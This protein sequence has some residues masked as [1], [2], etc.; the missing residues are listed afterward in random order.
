MAEPSTTAE[1]LTALELIILELD[2]MSRALDKPAATR[3][4]HEDRAVMKRGIIGIRD[5][6]ERLLTWLSEARLE[7]NVN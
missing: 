5:E 2:R 7:G 1:L 3:V 4:R 6:A